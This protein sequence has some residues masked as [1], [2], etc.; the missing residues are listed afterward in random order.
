[1]WE[2]SAVLDPTLPQQR[3]EKLQGRH[4]P[5][6]AGG[7]RGGLVALGA[8]VPEALQDDSRGSDA[9]GPCSPPTTPWGAMERLAW[10]AAPSLPRGQ[11]MV[12]HPSRC[13]NGIACACLLVNGL[14]SL[15]GL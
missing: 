8:S 3:R 7:W 10:L 11:P 15:E 2:P 14:G 6:A 12:G 1:M 4:F 9:L 5:P 13:S